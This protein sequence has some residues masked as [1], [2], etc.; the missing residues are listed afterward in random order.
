MA[1]TSAALEPTVIFGVAGSNKI[2]VADNVEP[3]VNPPIVPLSAVML[4][5][6]SSVPAP[7][8]F[9]LSPLELFIEN[10]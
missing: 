2:F 4:P 8:N 6:I 10:L 5:V 7:S 3:T 1:S 9:K